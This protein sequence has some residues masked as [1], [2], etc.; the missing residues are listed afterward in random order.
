MWSI[1]EIAPYTP[2]FVQVLKP[3]NKPLVSAC[4]S[5]SCARILIYL[6]L[7]N[8]HFGVITGA[9]LCEDELKYA[10]LA[11]N[12]HCRG[13]S[14]V[15]TLLLHTSREKSTCLSLGCFIGVVVLCL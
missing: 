15:V 8:E 3:E 9:V 4:A 2:L 1:S 6:V 12:C 7:L 14:T 13:I 10:L 5:Q 11:N